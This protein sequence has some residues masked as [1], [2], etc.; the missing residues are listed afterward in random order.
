MRNGKVIYMLLENRV[1][2]VT[3]ASRG[4]GAATATCLAREGA[5]VYAAA[6]SINALE[7]LSETVATSGAPGKVIPVQMGICSEANRKSEIA[8]MSQSTGNSR[9]GQ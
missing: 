4:I 1:C 7:K 9:S 2:L 8:R 6:R 3:G 5:I